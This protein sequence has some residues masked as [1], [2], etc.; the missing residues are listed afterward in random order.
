MGRRG[1]TDGSEPHGPMDH[2]GTRPQP[3]FW[4]R[5][6]ANLRAVPTA[7]ICGGLLGTIAFAAPLGWL[8]AEYVRTQ[9]VV[10]AQGIETGALVVDHDKAG[11]RFAGELVV[12]P[13]DDPSL[14]TTLS[15][16]PPGTAVGDVIDIAYDPHNPGRVVAL[17][18]PLVDGTVGLV[19]LADVGLLALLT[20]LAPPCV[21]VLVERARTRARTG[22]GPGLRDL[23]GRGVRSAW[24]RIGDGAREKGPTKALPLFVAL[25]LLLLGIGGASTVQEIERLVALDSR[26]VPGTAVVTGSEWDDGAGTLLLVLVEGEHPATIGHWEGVPRSGELIDVVYDPQD[27]ET[28]AHAGVHPWGPH[29]RTSVAITVVS[30]LGTFFV[31]PAAVAG[32]VRGRGGRLR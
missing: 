26:G 12:S 2:D 10:A 18:A 24:R 13:R 31:A 20:V 17:D 29:Q 21:V 11:R 25:P 28:V 27:W 14:V 30:A 1:A 3:T 16:W 9:V 15:H 4:Q 22:T 8:S 32:L 7:R 5:R 23:A 19:L 6:S